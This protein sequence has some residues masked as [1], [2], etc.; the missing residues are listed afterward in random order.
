MLKPKPKLMQARWKQGIESKWSQG[1][2]LNEF[3]A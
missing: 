1:F 3:D 2:R